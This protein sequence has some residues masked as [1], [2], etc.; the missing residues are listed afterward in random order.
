MKILVVLA[1]LSAVQ[2][3]ILLLSETMNIEVLIWNMETFQSINTSEGHSLLITDVRFKP[4]SNLFA[5][6]SF[7]R[8][9]KIWDAERPN[10]S[11]YK[12]LGHSEQVMSVDF[13]P[14]KS[15]LLCSCDRNNEIR[16]WNVTR[17]SCT[18]VSKGATKQ[19]RFQPR[20]GKLLATAARNSVSLIDV[21]TDSLQFYLKG[22]T[23]DVLS[24][25]WD[26]SGKYIASVSEDSARIWSAM[27]GGKCIH[28]LR[29]DGNKFQSCTFHP[30]YSQLLIIGG[31]QSLVLWSPTESDKTWSVPAHNGLVAA[32]A[33][34]Q[35]TEMVA[36]ASHDQ[37][38]KLWK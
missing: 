3:V 38:M 9:V 18:R 28:E 17:F 24:I 35:R 10:K 16:L 1:L 27:S 5:T 15:E 20:C 26:A 31:Y 12:L 2:N 14:S 23:K 29:S 32:L 13:H 8:T 21:E 30:G 7:D 36:S 4:S 34:S 19:V 37:C 11:L 6:S 25:C 33:D 22:H